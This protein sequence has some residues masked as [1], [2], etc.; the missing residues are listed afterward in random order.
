MSAG[1]PQTADVVT[2]PS[3]PPHFIPL[4]TFL[5]A[6]DNG[7]GMRCW[8]ALMTT[9]VGDAVLVR[10]H[11]NGRGGC[12]VGAVTLALPS[13]GGEGSEPVSA[14]AFGI[15]CRRRR[16]GCSFCGEMGLCPL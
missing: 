12:D 1:S 11:G 8:F 4:A 13:G 7:R 16:L 10:P 5:V 6:A 3:P 2:P 9:V 15:L 14:V